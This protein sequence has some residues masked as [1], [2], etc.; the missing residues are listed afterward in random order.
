MAIS[1]RNG[2]APRALGA[3]KESTFVG[4]TI[5]RQWQLSLATAASSVSTTLTSLADA[6]S[7][8]TAVAI[9]WRTV[10]SARGSAA[11]SFET[12]PISTTGAAARRPDAAVIS[13]PRARSPYD[14]RLRR[15]APPTRG[16]S[17]LH[18]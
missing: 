10:G 18:G 14:R 4:L 9:A 2:G 8:A 11:H 7:V 17:R 1:P 13:F 3:E 16:G 15:C 6:D 5:P 12:I